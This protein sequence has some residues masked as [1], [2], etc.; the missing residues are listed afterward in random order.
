MKKKVIVVIFIFMI[1]LAGC[2]SNKTE[3]VLNAVTE[4]SNFEY[5]ILTEVT[6]DIKSKFSVIEGF[7]I[8]ML[9]DSTLNPYEDDIDLFMENNPTT[10]Y[11]VTAY[12]DHLDSGEYI[13]RIDTSDPDIYVYDLSVGDTYSETEI[14]DYMASLGFYPHEEINSTYINEQ[15]RIRIRLTNDIIVKLTVEVEV[16]NKAG[17][18]F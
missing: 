6:E 3:H 12:P 18:I 5:V 13:T 17:I 8:Y 4:H 2:Q 11:H 10:Y 14:M 1:L 7:G 9:V 16:T 15:V